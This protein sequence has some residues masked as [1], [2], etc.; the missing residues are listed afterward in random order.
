MTEEEDFDKR[1]PKT[2]EIL[3]KQSLGFF[4]RKLVTPRW[5][6]WATIE[7]SKFR[8]LIERLISHSNSLE[9]LLESTIVKTTHLLTAERLMWQ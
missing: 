7:E 6:K 8:G 3:L 2:T 1:F 4:E 9:G 5:S